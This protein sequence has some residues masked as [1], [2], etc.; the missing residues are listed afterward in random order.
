MCVYITCRDNVPVFRSDWYYCRSSKS[1]VAT[2]IPSQGRGVGGLG[3][4]GEGEGE[5][6]G[7]RG[8]E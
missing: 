2:V 7:K 6:E 1:F 8:E 4:G 3:G 5:G